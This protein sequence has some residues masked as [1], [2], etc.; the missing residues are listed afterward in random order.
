[1]KTALVFLANGFE[2]VEAVTPIDFLR[3]AG[4]KVITVGIK[5][6]I[7]EGAHG[8]KISADANLE[9]ILSYDIN[10][11]DALVLPG[12]MPGAE[13]IAKEEKVLHLIDQ[14]NSYGK[15]IAAIC[16]SPGVILT[17]TRVLNN[18]K[19]TCYPGFEKYFEAANYCQESV[20]V[21]GNIITS[22]GPGTAAAF[23]IEII[24]K[25]CDDSIAEKIKTGTLQLF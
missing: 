19:V 6:K 5:N 12:G 25:L 7:V 10:K 15:I 22:R 17:K 24:K 1:M 23:S 13:N 18:K 3:R 14:L 21:D 16:A 2:E 4:L 9:D 11:I 8:I 20:V